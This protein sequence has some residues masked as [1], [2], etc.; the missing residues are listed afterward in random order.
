MKKFVRRTLAAML[1]IVMAAS[2]CCIAV[3]AA[4]TVAGDVV[5]ASDTFHTLTFN[6]KNGYIVFKPF[7]L[8]LFNSSIY[9]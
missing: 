4:T 2:V 7:Y 3:P 9:S 6:P 5:Y 8:P 1:A